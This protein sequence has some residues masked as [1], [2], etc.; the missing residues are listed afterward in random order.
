MRIL[1]HIPGDMAGG[2]LGAAEM[3]R[4]ERRLNEWAGAGT[5]VEVADSP[6]GPRSIESEAEEALA[7]GPMIAAIRSRA[8]TPDAVIVGCFGDPGLPAL[9]ELLGRPVVGP[10]EASLHAA[11]QLGA[12]VGVVTVLDRVI[13]LLDR[14]ARATAQWPIYA[15]SIAVNVPVLELHRDPA[16]RLAQIVEAGRRLVAREGADVLVL[17]CMSMAFLD[18]AGQASAACGVPVVNPARAALETAELLLSLGADRGTDPQSSN[19]NPVV[20]QEVVR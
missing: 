15:G 12:R 5:G 14:L 1:Y 4:R 3:A 19:E 10:F 20:N 8:T 17:G 2:P 6:G 13:P 9:R 7:V 16:A 11:A 18:V